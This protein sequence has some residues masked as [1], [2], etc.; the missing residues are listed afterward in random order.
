MEIE[1]KYL[2]KQL[3]ENLGKY[4]HFVI[5][6]G[7]LCTKPTIRI[8]RKHPG[9]NPRARHENRFIGH[10]LCQCVY[11][12]TGVPVLGVSASKG[13]SVIAQW[14]PG[15]AYLNDTIRRMHAAFD[16]CAAHGIV[17]RHRFLLWCQG[18]SDGD[19][20]TAPDVYAEQFC[21][22]YETL[23]RENIEHCFLI[24]IGEYNGPAAD[25]SY[26]AIR[27]AQ[28]ALANHRSDLTV[29]SRSFETMKVRGLMKDAFHYYQAGYN[30]TGRTA[31]EACAVFVEKSY[32]LR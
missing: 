4:P 5:E 25:I 13:G 28:Y 30:E 15:G 8:R 10:F 23:R 19:H 16:F 2:V 22:M 27:N 14:Q 7:Y 32:P 31:G 20:H 18:E 17:L 24:G 29:V 3:P 26:D 11:S 21:R 6:Q 1:R 9:R 12:L